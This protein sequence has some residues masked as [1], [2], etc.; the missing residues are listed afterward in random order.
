MNEL[1][2][3][4]L[5][6]PEEE[7]PMFIRSNGK[8]VGLCGTAYTALGCPEFVNIFFDEMKCRVMIKRAE[9]D[10][11]N[12]IS[13][14]A[15][16]GGRNMYLCNKRLAKKIVSMFGTARIYGHM[17]AEGTLVF[18]TIEEKKCQN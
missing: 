17:A 18:D 11:K 10:Y 3:F 6:R 1:E 2:G 5:W 15:H 9:P 14:T 7:K 12:I 8:G 16:S 4:V 13:I